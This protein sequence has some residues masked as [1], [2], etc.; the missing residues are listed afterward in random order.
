MSLNFCSSSHI[1]EID[2]KSSDSNFF[3]KN[4]SWIFL[5]NLR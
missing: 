3:Q 4:K 5:S 2:L 1:L